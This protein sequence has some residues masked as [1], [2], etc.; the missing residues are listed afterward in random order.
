MKNATAE[1]HLSMNVE[2][3]HCEDDIN[4]LELTELTDDGWIYNKTMP[5][6]RTWGC[7]DFRY[8]L[9]CPSCKENFMI[10]D[11]IY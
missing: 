10:K 1:I 8:K 11:V 5:D 9:Q 4:L 2:C 6:D 7:E 3:P